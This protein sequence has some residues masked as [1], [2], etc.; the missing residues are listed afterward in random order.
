MLK[1]G[2]C[3]I[4]HQYSPFEE[5]FKETQNVAEKG[6]EGCDAV[7]F[8]GG[9]DIHPSLYKQGH[10]FT[11][12]AS[13]ATDKVG[14]PLLS[15]RDLFEWNVMKHCKLKKIPMI[16]VCRGAQLACAFAGG[17]LIQ[18]VTHHGQTHTMTTSTG[19]TIQTTSAHHQMLYPFDVEHHMLAWSTNN[20]STH[21]K[22]DKG[23]LDDMWGRVEPEVVYF[24]EI[25]CLAIQG[26]PE[27][28]ENGHPFANYCNEMVLEYL[29]KK[30]EVVA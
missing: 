5:I 4:G 3:P 23:T 28:V 11:N 14:N 21:Y 1:L 26:H 30:E 20:R 13:R 12:F 18:D 25:N 17:R 8:W 9:T 27:W 15:Q 10:H 24:P 16:G 2:Y 29:L 6:V 7:V 22:D 19:K